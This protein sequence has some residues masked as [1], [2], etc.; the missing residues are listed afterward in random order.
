MNPDP[1]DGVDDVD[2][3]V[4][5][6]RDEPAQGQPATWSTSGRRNTYSFEF[7]SGMALRLIFL[8]HEW[9]MTVLDNRLNF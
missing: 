7:I 1:G 4:G 8:N 6:V 2:E 3:G 5:G 9:F